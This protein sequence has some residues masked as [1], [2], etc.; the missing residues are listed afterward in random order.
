[1]RVVGDLLVALVVGDICA[2][3]RAVVVAF[4]GSKFG[5][6]KAGKLNAGAAKV[7]PAKP[8]TIT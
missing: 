8:R 7:T 4:W 2:V 3:L 5:K 6:L 1:V